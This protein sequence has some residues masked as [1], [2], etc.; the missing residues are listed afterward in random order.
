MARAPVS[1]V[2][3]CSSLLEC[4]QHHSCLCRNEE[5]ILS[6][7]QLDGLRDAEPMAVHIPGGFSQEILVNK[8]FAFVL[9][10]G[11]FLLKS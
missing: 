11:G 2:S 4:S 9:P 5:K 10:F 3:V 8:H 7:L 1:S 6:H